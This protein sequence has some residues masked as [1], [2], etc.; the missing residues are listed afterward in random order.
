MPARK[1]GQPQQVEKE[2]RRAN[3]DDFPDL[4]PLH[5]G[6][7]SV[8]SVRLRNGKLLGHCDWCDRFVNGD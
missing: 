1:A 7:P 3:D 4:I 8:F 2:G 6:P 5:A